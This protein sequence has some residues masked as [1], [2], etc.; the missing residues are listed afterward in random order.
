MTWFCHLAVTPRNRLSSGGVGCGVGA[1]SGPGSC[2]CCASRCILFRAGSALSRS[3]AGKAPQPRMVPSLGFLLSSHS[4]LQGLPLLSIAMKKSLWDSAP[5]LFFPKSGTPAGRSPAPFIHYCVPG[6]YHRAH[7][8]R[9][10]FEVAL[11]DE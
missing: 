6:F 2:P 4:Q 7:K 3:L 8:S 1:S 9:Q 10:R 11:S 5:C